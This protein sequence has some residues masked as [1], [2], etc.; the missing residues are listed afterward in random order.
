MADI[1]RGATTTDYAPQRAAFA[2]LRLLVRMPVPL[3]AACW[4]VFL[5]LV[6]IFGPPLIGDRANLS[7]LTQRFVFPFQPD[8]GLWNILGTD[9]LGRSELAQVIVGARTSMLVAGVSVGIAAALGLIIGIITGYVG[10]WVD[11]A[12]MRVADIVITMP[13]LLLALVVLF[14]LS[15]NVANLVAVLAIARLPVYVRVARAQT[16]ELRERVFVESARAIGSGTMRILTH[17]IA[18]MIVPTITTVAVLEVA[19][20]MLTAAG[21]SFLGVGL[22]RPDIDWGMMVSEGRSYLARAWWVTLFPGIAIF[23]LALAANIVSNWMR[24]VVDPLQRG[25]LVGRPPAR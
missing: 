10:G 14:I 12:I 5:V 8:K 15:P 25:M 22:Q 4:M 24:A 3:I 16:L 1:A 17:D 6:A 9:S 21:L 19:Q 7:D 13:S 20:V 2:N 23:S 18:P 11:T